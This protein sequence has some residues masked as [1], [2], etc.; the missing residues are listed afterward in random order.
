MSHWVLGSEEHADGTRDVTIDFNNDDSTGQMSGSLVFKGRTYGISGSWAASG[1]V[2]GRNASAFGLYGVCQ[3]GA[4]DFVGVVG[5]M[6][7]PGGSPQSILM[8]LD[9]ASSGDGEQFGWDGELLPM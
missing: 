9:R 3:E 5:I 1:S 6:T 8:N 2:P 7:G 4:T